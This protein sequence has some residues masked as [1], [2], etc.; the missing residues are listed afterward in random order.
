VNKYQFDNFISQSVF[1]DIG[2]P[3]NFEKNPN[4]PSISSIE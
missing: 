4:I 2:M 3:V 1:I